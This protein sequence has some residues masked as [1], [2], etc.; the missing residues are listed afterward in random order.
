[1]NRDDDFADRATA[2]LPIYGIRFGASQFACPR[3]V[4][5]D[6]Q[7]LLPPFQDVPPFQR[8]LDIGPEGHDIFPPNLNPL[9]TFGYV[10]V[11]APAPF[12]EHARCK[13]NRSTCARCGTSQDRDAVHFTRRGRGVI[14]RL[15]N[16]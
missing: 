10:F 16:R 13:H 12:G 7:S 5:R 15:T 8:M 3:R 14:G 2:P 1:M 6:H 4:E 11:N 9:K